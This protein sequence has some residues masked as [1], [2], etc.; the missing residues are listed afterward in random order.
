MLN[1]DLG[2]E[3]TFGDVSTTSRMAFL[4]GSDIF[5]VRG[6]PADR[7]AAIVAV[8]AEVA[9]DE[10]WSLNLIYDG[11]YGSHTTSHG[12]RARVSWRW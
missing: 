2:W 11:A 10:D 6:T 4:S 9:L 5:S 1:L 8:G 12:G 3:H 7:N